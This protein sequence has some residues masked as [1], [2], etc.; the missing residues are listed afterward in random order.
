MIVNSGGWVWYWI[1]TLAILIIHLERILT[2][3]T[4]Q[5][6][7]VII[8]RPLWGLWILLCHS[9]LSQ[10]SDDMETSRCSPGNLLKYMYILE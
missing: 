10:V 4:P 1:D 6:L 8:R 3:V 2:A 9:D 7:E 5:L